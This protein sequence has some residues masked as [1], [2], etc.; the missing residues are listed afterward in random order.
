M[1]TFPQVELGSKSV[2]LREVKIG[3]ALKVARIPESKNER[4]LSLFLASILDDDQLPLN[5]SVQERYFL[6]MEYLDASK[7]TRIG[8][9]FDFSKYRLN[10]SEKWIDEIVIGDL[11]VKHL[12][13]EQAELLESVSEDL[14]DWFIGTM[15]IRIEYKGLVEIKSTDSRANQL[16]ALSERIKVFESM[17]QSEA[18]ILTQ[19]YLIACEQMAFHLRTGV[20]RMGITILAN[21]GTDDAPARFRAASAFGWIAKQLDGS[22]TES[23]D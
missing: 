23:S 18:D 21:G 2:Q 12:T 20:D 8:V 7:E 5:L 1:L 13:G 6:L 9:D 17:N 22:I 16:K 19:N 3:E 11:T 4:R 10:Q 15:L 14:A